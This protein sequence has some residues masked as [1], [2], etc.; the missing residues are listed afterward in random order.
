MRRWV[1]MVL[2]LLMASG[3]GWFDGFAPS[4][5]FQ[6]NNAERK[7]WEALGI[8]S[9]RV[10]VEVEKYNERRR[11]EVVVRDGQLEQAV[12]R[13]WSDDERAWE[14]PQMLS[15]ERGEPYTVPGLFEMV[16]GELAGQQRSVSA[17]YNETYR[18]PELIRL[19]NVH[20][21]NG[22]VLRDTEV[23]VRVL[24]FEPLEP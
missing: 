11:V 4:A 19:G 20:D 22:T 21:Q 3:C 7:A 17:R 15:E 2:V 16:G 1:V 18:F 8:T 6:T 5:S 13:Y 14:A 12:L 23:V 9:Y 10:L 24:E